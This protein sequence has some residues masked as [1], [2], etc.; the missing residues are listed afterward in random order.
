MDVGEKHAQDWNKCRQF[1]R[2][3]SWTLAVAVESA[4]LAQGSKFDP[5]FPS[6]SPCKTEETGPSDRK[7]APINRDSFDQFTLLSLNQYAK[8]LQLVSEK[9]CIVATSR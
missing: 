1:D 3:A 2:E 9:C 6:A 8:G 7:T 4:R 5:G